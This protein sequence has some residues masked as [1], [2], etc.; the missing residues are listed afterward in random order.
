MKKLVF[1]PL[2]D[3]MIYENPELIAGPILAFSATKPT[4]RAMTA[5]TER[6]ASLGKRRSRNP[7]ARALVA[8]A[9]PTG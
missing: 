2:S 3:E 1:V 6:A 7:P 9:G 5:K 4:G 8:A